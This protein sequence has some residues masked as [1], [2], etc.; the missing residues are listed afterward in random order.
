VEESGDV[1][2][3]IP[4]TP[5]DKGETRVPPGTP[6]GDLG[7]GTLHLEKTTYKAGEQIRV[8]FTASDRF[9]EGA[10]VGII[11]SHIP[12]GNESENDKN[13]LSYE[14][15]RGRRSGTLTFRAPDKPGSYDLRMH[16][17]DQDGREVASVTFTVTEVGAD[18]PTIQLGK[19]RFRPGEKMQVYFTAP[20]SF[21]EN[22]W[23]GIIPSSVPHGSEARNDKNDLAYEYLGGLTSGTLSFTAPSAPGSY[24]LRMHDTDREGKEVASVT[25]QVE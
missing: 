2:P 1:A 5:G 17:T 24:D 12:H 21:P 14:Y 8:R 9:L 19:A 11:P 13:D 18:K 6:R 22:A 4:S 15:L 20:L 3:T 10:W 23:V 25:F 16:D 7:G